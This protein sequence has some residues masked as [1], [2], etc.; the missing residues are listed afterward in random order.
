VRKGDKEKALEFLKKAVEAG[1]VDFG[2]IEQDS[3]LDG[4][5]DTDGYKEL[6][7]KKE[8]YLKAA[9]EKRIKR[10]KERAGEKYR[11]VRDE[12]RKLVIISDLKE[13]TLERFLKILRKYG[14]ALHKEFFE[15][16]PDYYILI[17]IPSSAEEY[18]E[19]FGGRG[20]AAGFYNP[21]TRTLTV[22]IRTGTGTMTHEFT[23]AL[24]YADMAGLKQR[25]PIWIIEGFGSLFEQCTIKEGRPIGLLNWRL[26]ILKKAIEED[27]LFP[28]REF[29]TRSG[30]AFRK[31][32]SIAYA[33]T[34]YIF[35][36]LQEKNLL[37]KFY[38]RYTETYKEDKTGIKA[39]EDVLGKK[40][41]EFQKE[42]LEF[43]KPLEYSRGSGSRPRLGVYLDETDDGLKIDDVVKDSAAEAAGL[44][45]GD[46]I[47]E[48]DG[49][50]TKTVSDLRDVLSK[51][52]KGD[53]VEL[54]IKRGDKELT[55]T[56]TLK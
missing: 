22:N 34:R 26:P 37:K 19:K 46:V 11:V 50:K 43:L 2:H 38:K 20:G 9:T 39:L 10:I 24:H 44:K 1:F 15:H 49:K 8:E 35:Y 25:H 16:K 21:S 41:E 17:I 28:M 45:K 31:N 33:Q 40:V 54:K 13:E 7:K 48:V 27:R 3:D 53:K 56:A 51:K 18:R 23:H 14:D 52:K 32:A 47:L 30:E 29:I 55:L 12:E 42:W 6:M 4:I 5:R 36:Y